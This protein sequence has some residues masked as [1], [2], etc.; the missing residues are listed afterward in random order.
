LHDGDG[1]TAIGDGDGFDR[2]A[3]HVA[4]SAGVEFADRDGLYGGGEDGWADVSN[5]SHGRRGSIVGDFLGDWAGLRV[6][7]ERASPAGS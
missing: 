6:A 1:G 4:A 7:K 3:A 2:G 5:G